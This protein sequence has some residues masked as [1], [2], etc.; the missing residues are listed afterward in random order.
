[1]GLLTLRDCGHFSSDNLAAIFRLPCG[2][3][4]PQTGVG[5]ELMRL[6]PA[7]KSGYA[8]TRGENTPFLHLRC[9]CKVATIR[10]PPIL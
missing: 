9:F 1:M 7:Y 4:E 10:V 3:K 8:T 6:K 5:Y 2:S